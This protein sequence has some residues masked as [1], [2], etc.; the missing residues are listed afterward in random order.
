[1][2]TQSS[3]P[4]ALLPL[5]SLGKSN[6]LSFT[7]RT[8]ANSSNN[9]CCLRA[10]CSIGA[11]IQTHVL[12]LLCCWGDRTYRSWS[13][14]REERSWDNCRFAMVACR[15]SSW[16]ECILVNVCKYL[17]PLAVD[18]LRTAFRNYS[19]Q[20]PSNNMDCWY[21]SKVRRLLSLHPYIFSIISISS[22][23]TAKTKKS[24]KEFSGVQNVWESR[25]IT[26]IKRNIFILVGFSIK[27]GGRFLGREIA[28]LTWGP[29][30]GQR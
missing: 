26:C 27:F 6:Y 30:F 1:M 12:Q 17:L 15:L 9:N 29:V 24:I 28:H 22:V 23:T 11:Y 19:Q 16:I 5:L 2:Y 18:V 3:L 13:W 8:K 14:R 7:G 25:V 10:A 20:V 21:L 4:Y